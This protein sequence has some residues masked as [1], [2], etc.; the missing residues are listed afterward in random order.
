MKK[1]KLNIGIIGLG[2]VGQGVVKIIEDSKLKIKNKTN[3]EINIIGISAY[4]KSKKRDINI[5]SYTWYDN[6]LEMCQQGNLDVLIE[7]IGGD[8]G[9]A[10]E[11]IERAI[12]NKK[13]IIT[14]NKALIAK[15]GNR[16]IRLAESIGVS[17]LYEAAVAG[18]IP[19]IKILKEST[20]SNDIDALYGIL[21]GTSNYIL[22][23]MEE[24][25]IT[26]KAALK[27]AQDLG[28]AEADP[29]F[30]I[31]GYDAAHKLSI[32][33]SIIFS[34]E[35]NFDNAEVNGISD[36][37]LDDIKAPEPLSIA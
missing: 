14:A 27:K 16:L 25:Q 6:P 9:I 32:L 31:G 3:Q 30:D 10:L 2:S 5:K 22:T 37:S 21:N 34:H 36:I 24:E 19:I 11:V 17:F 1:S 33:S 12:K 28:F 35:I 8:E 18:A 4:D 20:S 23:S 13:H 15:H 29:A 26:F 7:L